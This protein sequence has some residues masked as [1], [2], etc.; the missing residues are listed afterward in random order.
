MNLDEI[1]SAIFPLRFIFWGGI[2]CVLDFSFSN[3]VNGSGIKFDCLN[4]AVGMLFIAWGTFKLASLYV[5]DRYMRVM[6]FVKIVAALAVLDAIRDHFITPYTP[7][8]IGFLINVFGL[9]VL[10]ATVAFCVAMRWF[11]E[12]A[13]LQ[14][15]AASWRLTTKLFLFIYV[16]PL[17]FFYIAGCIA[18][19]TD[20][21]FHFDLGP[22]GLILLPLFI[23]PIVHLFIST[24]R[25]R[26]AADAYV[27]PAIS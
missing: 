21:S 9:V 19:L 24:S 22:A 13:T 23:W 3:T 18:I 11:C 27:A 17:G 5:D 6:S 15:A 16:L 26:R 12:R 2:L 7:P 10:A 4:D 1:K 25:M 20:A 8:I 14:T